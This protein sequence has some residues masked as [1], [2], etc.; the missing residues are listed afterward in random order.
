MK[1]YKIS[2]VA[3]KLGLSKL[4]I[5]YWIRKGKIKAVRPNKVY[6]IPE[7]ELKR[8]FKIDEFED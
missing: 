1:Y 6:L 7:S 3:E 8:V 4:T 5:W 2:E